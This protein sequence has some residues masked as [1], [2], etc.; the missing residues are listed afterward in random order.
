MNNMTE[1]AEKDKINEKSREIEILARMRTLLALERNYLAEERTN[2][3]EFR[4]GLALTLVIPPAIIFL[5][6]LDI[7]IQFY[8]ALLLYTFILSI[9]TFGVWMLVHSWK[10][11]R[12]IK[13]KK[14]SVKESE[15]KIMKS[16]KLASDLLSNF[17][18]L[19]D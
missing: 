14:Q 16:S 12:R 3:A 17:M 9:S 13:K 4:T 8:I 15:K 11:L 2:L 19:D 18:F 10:K 7:K 1:I 6:S 5:L